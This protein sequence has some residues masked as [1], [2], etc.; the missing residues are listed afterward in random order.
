MPK[1]KGTGRSPLKERRCIKCAAKRHA[2][3]KKKSHAEEERHATLSNV[4]E[5]K[6]FIPKEWHKVFEANIGLGAQ[7]SITR[8]PGAELSIGR[9]YSTLVELIDRKE[10]NDP[11]GHYYWPERKKSSE[12]HLTIRILASHSPTYRGKW[13]C[14]NVKDAI[15][16]VEQFPIEKYAL[17]KPHST[18]TRV[19]CYSSGT[20]S[21]LWADTDYAKQ[22]K[23][24]SII[25]CHSHS[26]SCNSC[27]SKAQRIK[28]NA[29]SKC[30][31]SKSIS[32]SPMSNYTAYTQ[33]ELKK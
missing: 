32:I 10:T 25:Y 16:A 33:M 28:P 24:D 7:F 17:G 30:K 6:F 15:T 8:A 4:D 3:D 29:W 1:C 20:K 21:K 14:G 13:A 18:T 9:V 27:K 23:L 5:D 26:R 11:T 19:L 22:D 12:I 31:K 2:T